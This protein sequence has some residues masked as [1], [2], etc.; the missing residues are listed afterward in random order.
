MRLRLF[1]LGYVANYGLVWRYAGRGGQSKG[2]LSPPGL[3]VASWLMPMIQALP[4]TLP[5]NSAY[6]GLEKASIAAKTAATVNNNIR[7][8]TNKLLLSRKSRGL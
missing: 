6:A 8:F 1:V 3:V 2:M 7:R 4:L 5:G